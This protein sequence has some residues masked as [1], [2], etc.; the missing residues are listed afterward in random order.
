[1]HGGALRRLIPDVSG[2]PRS[3]ETE[4]LDD[5]DR[6]V[7]FDAIVDL[8]A[9]V[10]QRAPVIVVLD[11]L[12]WADHSSL[13]FLRHL[14]RAGVPMAVTIV[15][16][17][18]DT[19]LVRTHPLS[20]VLG[21]LRRETDVRRI[22]LDGLDESEIT[23]L[24]TLIAG[25]DV[26]DGTADLAALIAAETAGNPFFVGEVLQH[27]AESGAI[28]QGPDGK[29]TSDVTDVADLGVPEGVREVVGRRLSALSDEANEALRVA[30]VLGFEFDISI[31]A[32]L[33]GR[34]VDEVIDVLDVP[35]RRGLLVEGAA[36]DRYRFP[37]ALVRQVLYEELSM[38]RRIRLHA[39]VADTLEAA[40]KGTVEERAHHALVS[41]AVSSPERAVELAIAAASE[42]CERLAYEQA[43][44]WYRR[45]LEAEEII[46]PA[47]DARRAELLIALVEARN[48]A[49]EAVHA[50][51]D[52]VA[53]AALARQAGRPELLAAAAIAYG[54][55]LG[56]WLDF[57]DTTGLELIDEALGSVE[58]DELRAH[59]YLAKAGWLKF[60]SDETLL[61]GIVHEA[62][63][64]ASRSDNLW[65]RSKAIMEQVELRRMAPL[66][67]D[68]KGA[69][70]EV[71]ELAERMP[72]LRMWP[73]Y[74]RLAEASY[75]GD[76]KECA[77]QNRHLAEL[78]EHGRAP[79][80]RWAAT[81]NAAWLHALRGEFDEALALAH[82]A[83][84]GDAAVGITASFVEWIQVSEIARLRGRHNEYAAMWR[85]RDPAYEPILRG[86][87]ADL[88][89]AEATGDV[90]RVPDLVEDFHSNFG[91]FPA[92][93]RVQNV[94]LMSRF[95]AVTSIEAARRAYELLGPYVDMWL[96]VGTEFQ[97]GSTAYALARYARRLGETDEAVSL[98]E[99]ALDSHERAQEVPYRA[100]IEV[101]L[102]D[103]LAERAAPGDRERVR[104]LAASALATA[105]AIGMPDVRVAAEALI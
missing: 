86:F 79:E 104:S 101:E 88:F 91:S 5:G 16:T 93:G 52:A 1:L 49:G 74:L 62:A 19:D 60:T 6:T 68:L 42:A 100:I 78:A 31:V 71:Q 72:R 76:M 14:A 99:R 61:P 77:L 36:L 50:R 102:A 8:L 11:D 12:H 13:Q 84:V 32:S 7:L 33:L 98:Y 55:G 63:R 35:V 64:I 90:E 43:I 80:A 75:R 9:R 105:N 56:L 73:A 44:S 4:A 25:D 28:Y 96:C 15:G 20:L 54:G 30:S 89:V 17:Y 2:F 95:A 85:D 41:A 82:A 45:A 46:E 69:A 10:S 51:T 18:R 70:D 58:D 65:L 34:D 53:A 94:V 87:P 29:W 27:L 38:S 3:D 97:V 81:S 59:L 22:A 57:D 67:V 21:D 40:N 26:G 92:A 47:D 23:Q 66:T 24:M 83:R 39:R 48:P 37:H 103:V